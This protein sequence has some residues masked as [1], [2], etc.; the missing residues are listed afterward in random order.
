MTFTI[1]AANFGHSPA[2]NVNIRYRIINSPSANVI[3]I[4]HELCPGSTP[5]MVLPK[6]FFWGATLFPGKDFT[7]PFEIGVEKPELDKEFIGFSKGE[8]LLNVIGCID[9]SIGSSEDHHQT[10]FFYELFGIKDDGK[11]TPPSVPTSVF[12]LK[13]VRMKRRAHSKFR[14]TNK[15]PQPDLN[16]QSPGSISANAGL[17]LISCLR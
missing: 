11:T 17:C 5:L 10:F 15:T 16:F 9:Y 13:K 2:T 8:L 4:Q 3:G 12:A 1:R 14:R 7:Q 6:S